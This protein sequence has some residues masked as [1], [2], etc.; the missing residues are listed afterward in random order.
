MMLCSI[1]CLAQDS[2][3]IERNE[4]KD[5]LISEA[6]Y[7][8]KANALEKESIN[9]KLIIEAQIAQIDNY[10]KIVSN[11]EE[12]IKGLQ[13]A[14]NSVKEA[15]KDQVKKGKFKQIIRFIEGMVV[16][17]AILFGILVIN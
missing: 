13:N 17:A 15:Y 6:E 9:T 14:L 16:G 1:L 3:L 10:V 12:V 7:K 11:N 4:L 5:I 2:V 8:S